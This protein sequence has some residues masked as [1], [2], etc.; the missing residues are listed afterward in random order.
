MNVTPTSGNQTE[1]GAIP[2]QT[3]LGYEVIDKMKSLVEAECPGVV[4][5]ADIITLAARDSIV[6]IVRIYGFIIN[7]TA[8]N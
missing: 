7:K 2:N 5:C 3:I 6:K 8:Y 4:S 1:K